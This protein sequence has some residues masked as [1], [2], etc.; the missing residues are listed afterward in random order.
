MDNEYIRHLQGSSYIDE[1]LGDR[2]KAWGKSFADKFKGGLPST[3]IPVTTP[4]PAGPAFPTTSPSSSSTTTPTLY[5]SKTAFAR[6]IQKALRIIVDAVKSDKS[7]TPDWLG[8]SDD[9]LKGNPDKLPE[10]EQAIFNR[11]QELMNRRLNEANDPDDD[12]DDTD[13]DSSGVRKLPGGK[14]RKHV[15]FAGQFLYNFSSKYRCGRHFTYPVRPVT[16]N[17]KVELRDLGYPNDVLIEVI[18]INDSLS[19]TIQV[20][21]KQDESSN[22]SVN[23]IDLFAFRHPEVVFYSAEAQDFSLKKMMDAARPPSPRKDSN[24]LEGAD[25]GVLSNIREMCAGPKSVVCLCLYAVEAR[26]SMEFKSKKRGDPDLKVAN[27]QGDVIQ[28]YQENPAVPKEL[29]ARIL[30]KKEIKEILAKRDESSDRLRRALK[31]IDYFYNNPDVTEPPPFDKNAVSVPAP[32]PPA[33]A[34]P[35]SPKTIAPTP[36]ATKP[37]ANAKTLR[38][39]YSHFNDAVEALIVAFKRDNKPIAPGNAERHILRCWDALIKDGTKLSDITAEAL[40]GKYNELSNPPREPSE[41]ASPETSPETSHIIPTPEPGEVLPAKP[42]R[43]K[44]KT[45]P[46]KKP[47]DR[48]E[49][50]SFRMWNEKII[51]PFQKSNFL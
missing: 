47:N 31:H 14:Q 7:H 4:S 42:K 37:T 34:K 10:N 46:T 48:E 23:T 15:D 41:P 16:E 25:P 43:S 8:D 21:I 22:A 27:P 50:R 6:I 35:S 40:L 24:N 2:L 45:P 13:T 18:W 29:A 1:G 12:N 38:K 36:S 3:P 26:R 20:N 39:R 44:R 9:F 19:N 17:N 5:E 49:D 28:Y 11:V 33:P 30:T 32:A 51:N